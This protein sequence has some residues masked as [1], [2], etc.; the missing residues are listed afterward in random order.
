M[1]SVGCG[2]WGV[3]KEVST[4]M[5]IKYHQLNVAV[6]FPFPFSFYSR[7]LWLVVFLCYNAG[8]TM[9]TGYKWLS[10]SFLPGASKS[11]SFGIEIVLHCSGCKNLT[12]IFRGIRPEAATHTHTYNAKRRQLHM[13]RLM[14]VILS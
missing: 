4:E 2:V 10:N 7:S 3:K 11:I 6:A 13:Q 8:H 1:S 12:E 5:C 9:A 14:A